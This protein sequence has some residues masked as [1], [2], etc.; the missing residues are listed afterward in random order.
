MKN[1]KKL[2]TVCIA[3]SV[4]CMVAMLLFV[5]NC[6]CP[7][8]DFNDYKGFSYS[9]VSDYYAIK[10][11]APIGRENGYILYSLADDPDNMFLQPQSLVKLPRYL[12]AR[13]DL[14]LPLPSKDLVERIEIEHSG[15]SLVLDSAKQDHLMGCFRGS[16]TMEADLIE[17][18][19]A[20]FEVKIIF[21]NYP[22][23]YYRTWIKR[24][25]SEYVLLLENKEVAAPI[26]ESFMLEVL[27]GLALNK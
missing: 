6:C 1:R 20:S 11:N 3:A 17:E 14:K 8:I 12:M 21:K 27:S 19:D 15:R 23:I 10:L 13:T 26:D 9:P 25:G 5:L 24:C 4:V 7:V 2:T 16:D 18:A 22:Q